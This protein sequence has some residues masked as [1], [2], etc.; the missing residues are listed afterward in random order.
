MS[1]PGLTDVPAALAG[2]APAETGGHASPRLLA[3]ALLA[4]L[5]GCSM[6]SR[7][8]PLDV[9]SQTAGQP[10][11]SAVSDRVRMRFD[12]AVGYMQAGNTQQAEIELRDVMLLAPQLA[13]PY[14]D[15]SILYR[16]EG[17]LDEAEEVLRS[18]VAHNDTS[19]LLWTQLGVM[20]RLKGQFKDSAASYERAI[21]ADPDYAPAYRNLGVVADLYLGDAERALTAFER[22]K[23]LTNEDKPVS[24][25]IAELRV[26]TGKPTKPASAPAAAQPG[27][28]QSA[29]ASPPTK[30]DD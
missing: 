3:V 21:A 17:K 28:P 24:S 12:R 20:Q 18:A 9:S 22:Y 2:A 1:L 6:F 13:A 19:A 16:R 7:V 27:A 10:G 4:G 25:W 11:A 14:I 29:A 8:T 30:A 15:L 23:A 5:A 26:R